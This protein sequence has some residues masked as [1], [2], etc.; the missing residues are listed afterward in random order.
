M[1]TSPSMGG[2]T[3]GHKYLKKK[4]LEEE[5]NE[6]K[7]EVASLGFVYLSL[8]PFV[9]LSFDCCIFFKRCFSLFS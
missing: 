4:K 8:S 7:R 9:F 3:L 6:G 2:N 1:E 5:G